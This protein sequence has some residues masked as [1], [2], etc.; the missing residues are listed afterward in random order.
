MTTAVE[1]T[2]ILDNIQKLVRHKLFHPLWSATEIADRVATLENI[3]AE[4]I[5]APEDQF[6]QRLNVWLC[7]F[8]LSHM[9]FFHAS[10]KRV[11]P[12][13]AIGAELRAFPNGDEYAWFVQHVAEGGVAQ[14]AG[15]RLGDAFISVN[16]RKVSPPDEPRFN[17]GE[18][19]QILVQRQNE[20]D[21]RAVMLDIPKASEKDRPP[22]VTSEPLSHEILGQ[23]I[24]LMRVATF[25]GAVGFDFARGVDHI[26]ARFKAAGCDRLIVDLRGNPGGGLGS[27]RLMSYLVPDRRPTG[28]SLTRKGKERRKSP[29]KLMRIGH[30]PKT[31]LGLWTMAFRFGLLHRDRSLSLWTEG[32]GAQ[33]FHGKTILLVDEFTRSAAEMIAAFACK[34]KIAILV[35]APTPGQVLGAANF[36]VGGDY[37]LRIPV[38]AWY[39][40]DGELIEGKG[41]VPDYNVK[42]ALEDLRAGR[43]VQLE[44][45]VHEVLAL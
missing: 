13:F 22:M 26:M 14:K 27:L 34:S 38:T 30:I 43:D 32:L 25:P 33:P 39:M 1:R 5:H 24:G 4:L 20:T 21:A 2:P 10:A 29:E 6:E 16:G 36:K 12:Q 19:H 17:L 41:V 15:I 44:R 45:T 8:G 42:P 11:P 18:A 28:Y 35:G 23:R 37:R 9:A 3:R 40:P 31:K 7:G